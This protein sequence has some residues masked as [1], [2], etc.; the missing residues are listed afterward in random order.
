MEELMADGLVTCRKDGKG[1][2][3]N[4][5]TDLAESDECRVRRVENSWARRSVINEILHVLRSEGA[6]PD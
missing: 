6:S 3:K 5:A 1:A 2:L 4:E